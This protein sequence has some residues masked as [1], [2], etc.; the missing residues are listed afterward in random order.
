MCIGITVTLLWGQG[1]R[2]RSKVGVKVRVKV[3]GR[4]QTSSMQR[5]ILGARLCRVHQRAI[6][7]ITS[8]RCLSACLKS[9]RVCG[10]LREC[11]Q[12]AFNLCMMWYCHILHNNLL[13]WREVNIIASQSTPACHVLL[14]TDTNG[15]R[16]GCHQ[17]YYLPASR[18]INISDTLES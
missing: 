10:L 17:V 13:A 16:A 8:P 4:G 11:G 3:I 5:S 18:L 15:W 2:S 12:S 1:Q 14:K 6:R 7:V 9:L